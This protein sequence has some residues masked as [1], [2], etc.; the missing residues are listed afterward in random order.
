MKDCDDG[1]DE[2][3]CEYIFLDFMPVFVDSKIKYKR[4]F[5]LGGQVK[6][7]THLFRCGSGECV[8]PDLVC[9][10]VPNCGD[11]S[12]EGVGCL[13]NNCSSISLSCQHYCISTPHGAVNL[14]YLFI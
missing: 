11:G 10:S 4:M 3:G 2:S 13:K 7:P 5:F 6:C 9:N 14:F 8:Q 1:S 12:D